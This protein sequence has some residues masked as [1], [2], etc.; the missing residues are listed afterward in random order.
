[1][2]NSRCQCGYVHIPN[3]KCASL[4]LLVYLQFIC[5]RPLHVCLF[6]YDRQC[7][8]PNK[9]NE[10]SVR[11]SRILCI[12]SRYRMPTTKKTVIMERGIICFETGE[13]ER[14]RTENQ[15]S[16]L[17]LLQF[18]ESAEQ[19]PFIYRQIVTRQELEY[20]LKK[21]GEQHYHNKFGV[22]YFS[23]HG[24][25]ENICLRRNGKDKVSFNNL[26]EIAALNEAFKNRHVHFSSCET[27][28]CNEEL[29]KQFK[30]NTGAKSI[31][32]Y[33]KGVNSTSAYINELAYFHQLCHYSTVS[34]LRK[35]MADYQTQLN[36]LGFEI[37]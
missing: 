37:Y 25:P 9:Q 5:V 27:L 35:H 31:S 1:M 19:I 17:P 23:F 22:V 33:T 2:A 10:Q 30:R 15:F 6:Y 11:H 32:G 7:E 28:N 21:I 13:F 29:I 3:G 26:A 4:N 36:K 16:A 12:N 14:Y 34:T 18:L 20:Y 8:G 24:E